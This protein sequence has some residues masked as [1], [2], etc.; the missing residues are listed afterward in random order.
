MIGHFVEV[1]LLYFKQSSNNIL[2]IFWQYLTFIRAQI[3]LTWPHQNLKEW[4]SVKLTILKCNTNLYLEKL[5]FLWYAS[6]LEHI[7][8]PWH[9]TKY[10]FLTMWVNRRILFFGIVRMRTNAHKFI[11]SWFDKTHI[12][13]AFMGHLPGNYSYTTCYVSNIEIILHKSLLYY[14][15]S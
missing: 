14:Y 1:F 9:Q 13:L 15:F 6:N 7:F 3:R 11:C 4:C 8:S 10:M 12:H 5:I 2:C